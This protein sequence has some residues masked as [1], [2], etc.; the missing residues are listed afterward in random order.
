MRLARALFT[1]FAALHY[2][3]LGLVLI[4]LLRTMLWSR[5]SWELLGEFFWLQAAIVAWPLVLALVFTLLAMCT[6]LESWELTS[7]SLTQYGIFRK[8][9]ID[10]NQLETLSWWPFNRMIVLK[11]ARYRIPL[12]LDSMEPAVRLEVIELLQRVIPASR[13][14]N[15]PRFCSQFAWPLWQ[16]VHDQQ[17]EN[18]SSPLSQEAAITRWNEHH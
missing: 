12:F 14:H 11:S 10:F 1:A 7:S 6:W 16:R 4:S 9:R 15:W 18:Q 17:T 13:Q 3:L 2:L 5:V 8:K